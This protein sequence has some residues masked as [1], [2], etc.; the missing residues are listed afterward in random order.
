ML[1]FK[2][3]CVRLLAP[4]SFVTLVLLVSNFRSTETAGQLV[5]IISVGMVASA[6]GRFGFD[7]LIAQNSTEFR[8]IS[9]KSKSVLA[10]GII[11][12][13]P[14]SLLCC[15]VLVF[16]SGKLDGSGLT[17]DLSALPV[18][19]VLAAGL[20]FLQLASAAFQAR[21]ETLIS[22]ITFPV[23]LYM[24]V[25]AA[26]F[27]ANSSVS[28]ALIFGI[29]AALLIAAIFLVRF[30]HAAFG[31]PDISWIIASKFFAYIRLA[32]LVIDWGV[33]VYVAFILGPNEVV[34]FFHSLQ[35]WL[36]CLHCR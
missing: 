18:T 21:N 29:S 35:E 14:T 7:Q 23:T 15:V 32:G 12:G 9:D 30:G 8:V 20:V 19:L 11:V 25:A 31:K 6:L 22:V 4:A 26:L 1:L 10:T 28:T 16:L 33:N 13:V 2:A 5:T 36:H 3:L 17:T 24:T 27:L 34:V